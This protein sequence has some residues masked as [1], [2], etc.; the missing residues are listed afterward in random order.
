MDEIANVEMANAWDGEEGDQ[1][2]EFADNYDE[3]MRSIWARFLTANLIAT[4]DRVLDIGCGNGQ[5]SRDAA[6]RATTGSVLGVDLSASMLAEARRRAVAENVSNVEFLQADA[7]V[8]AFE[9][10]GFDI[11]MSRYGMMFFADRAAAFTNI[12]AALRP[13]GRLAMLAWQV[14][15][16][17]EWIMVVRELLAAGRDLSPPPGAPGPAALADADATRSML[18]EAGFVDIEF[19]SI[20]EPMSF[21]S[22]ADDAYAFVGGIGIVKGL[23]SDL[24]EATRDEG[25]RLLKAALK[26]HETPDGVCFASAS[27]LITARRSG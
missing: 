25:H 5:S 26:A 7:Q 8:H 16:K 1:W 13:G 10:G 2:T 4:G 24:D 12:A 6:R 20:E 3:S 19:E 17:N 21:G 14:V 9:P 18:T 11:A 22:D 15:A 23:S 27:W